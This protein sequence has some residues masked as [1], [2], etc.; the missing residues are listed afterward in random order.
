MS[1]MSLREWRAQEVPT[2][3]LFI[4]TTESHPSMC[5]SLE[6]CVQEIY[7]RGDD[8][9]PEDVCDIEELTEV[10]VLTPIASVGGRRD[11]PAFLSLAIRDAVHDA[12]KQWLYRVNRQRIHDL[13]LAQ[14]EEFIRAYYRDNGANLHAPGPRIILTR[15]EVEAIFATVTPGGEA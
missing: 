9:D 11:D 13:P 12:V 8:F 15:A 4:C 3:T 14:L 1:I 7:G 6:E 2:G 5:E 10:Q